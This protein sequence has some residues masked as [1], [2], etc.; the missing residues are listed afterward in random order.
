MAAGAAASIGSIGTEGFPKEANSGEAMAESVEE[1]EDVA[2]GRKEKR[3][4]VGGLS[5]WV[6]SA[7]N[8]LFDRR[9]D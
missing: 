3:A 9:A 2:D 8:L 5:G 1:D 4:G 6:V 7:V